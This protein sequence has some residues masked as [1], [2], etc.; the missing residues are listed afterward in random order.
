MNYVSKSL[1][2]LASSGLLTACIVDNPYAV[3]DSTAEMGSGGTSA[4]TGTGDA[5]A[6][7]GTETAEGDGDGDSGAGDGDGDGDGDMSPIPATCELAQA[8]V[9]N[10]GCLFFGVDLDTHDEVEDSQFAITV[11]NVQPDQDASVVVERKQDGGWV[12]AAGPVMV[13][14]LDLHSFPLPDL[15]QDD[16]G[17]LVGG[18]YRVSSDLPI[19]AYQFNPV[20][21]VESN[22]SDASMLYPVASWDHL[23]DL[24]GWV[25]TNDEFQQGTYATIVAAVDGT[26]VEVTPS[27]GT[28]SGAGVP[29]GKAN[30][31][32]NITLD[33][34][35]IVEVMT[36][37][38]NVGLSGT[39]INSDEAHPIGVFS[40]HECALIPH[41]VFAC[42]HL[43]DQ[44]SGKHLWGRHFIASRMPA[45]VT[46]PPESTLWQIYASEDATTVTLAADAEITGLPDSPVNMSAGQ[47]VEFYASGV[48]AIPGDFEILAD[49]PIAVINYMIG[50]QNIA[51]QFEVGDPAMVQLGPVSQYLSRYVVLVPGTWVNDY[52]V[53]TR[54]LDAQITLD[55]QPVPDLDFVPVANSGY[56]VARLSV[57]DGVHVIDGTKNFAVVV[58]GYDQWDSY[59]YLGGIGTAV[60]NPNPN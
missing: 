20:D 43:E 50:S 10:V 2:L 11:V 52:L 39:R 6:E 55:G 8:G 18:A 40:G 56:E 27:V 57:A 4:G 22:L 15:H 9:S 1:V 32:F 21:G 41:N 23:N 51:A 54:E 28:L 46:G 44:L 31:P 30:E 24:V 19:V 13:G 58:V 3:P 5:T 59:A 14:A 29:A 45:R 16:S 7:A 12:N 26:V 33:E 25:S 34:G 49:K 37:T 42:D 60:I 36:K 35:D 48:D 47:V 53:I 17:K 38:Q